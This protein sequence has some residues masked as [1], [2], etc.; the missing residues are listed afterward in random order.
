MELFNE[1]QAEELANKV[2]VSVKEKIKEQIADE[3]YNNLSG[4]LYEHYDNVKDKINGELIQA[5]TEEYVKNPSEY[6]FADL[7]RKMFDENK[8]V[9]VKTLTDEAIKNSVENVMLEYTHRDYHF[10]WKWK[11]G[12]VK[13]ILKNWDNFKDDERINEAFGREL[14]NR[15]NYIDSLKKQLDEIRDLV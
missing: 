12:I 4:Y 10:S 5:I 8:D 7:R 11:D 15:Q 14:D 3:F 9:L 6:K 2:L 1:K 13:F